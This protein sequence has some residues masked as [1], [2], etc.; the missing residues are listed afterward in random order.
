MGT[1]MVSFADSSK[2][3]NARNPHKMRI[4]TSSLFNKSLSDINFMAF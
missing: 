3:L 1:P 4:S 2:A